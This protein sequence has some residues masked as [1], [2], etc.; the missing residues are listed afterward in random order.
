MSYTKHYEPESYGAPQ[1]GNNYAQAQAYATPGQSN[2][3]SNGNFGGV[4][5]VVQQPN[6]HGSGLGNPHDPYAERPR[7]QPPPIGRWADGICDWP[8]NIWPS[9]YCVCCIFCGSWILGQMGEKV[10]CLKFSYTML[11]YCLVLVISLIIEI[12]DPGSSALFWGPMIFSFVHQICLRLHIVKKHQIQECST[13]PGC[14]SFGEFCWGCCC[15]CCSMCQMARYIYGYDKV[16][17]GDGDVYRKD[18]WAV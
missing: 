3:G 8:S 7:R 4:P 10:G 17:D 16:F 13:N 5:V 1:G 15:C 9:C 18:N 2:A 11:I 6:I 14:S 12:A